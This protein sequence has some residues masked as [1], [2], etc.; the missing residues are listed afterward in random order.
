MEQI[1]D[2]EQENGQ[3]IYHSINEVSRMLNLPTSLLRFWEKEF[4]TINPTKKGNGT[5]MYSQEDI[6]EIKLVKDLV[7]GRN[8]KLATARELIH[9]NREGALTT[10]ELLKHLLD[11]REQLVAI[12]REL[13]AIV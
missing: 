8:M 12:R 13:D 4:P 2:P 7:K 3:K 9:R 6:D 1:V 5:R 11:V 10:N